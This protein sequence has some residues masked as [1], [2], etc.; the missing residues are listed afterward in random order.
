MAAAVHGAVG[1]DL[2]AVLAGEPGQ[3]LADDVE[4]VVVVHEEGELRG[5]GVGQ[6]RDAEPARPEHHL[7]AVARRLAREVDGPVARVAQDRPAR[8]LALPRGRRR[9][10]P[11]R[12][13]RVR[14]RRAVADRLVRRAGVA[15]PQQ[16]V[17]RGGCCGRERAEEEGEYGGLVKHFGKFF[18]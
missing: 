3:G 4:H 14:E 2:A 13:V 1:L 9:R 11:A 6:A 15:R 7:V 16:R 5:V 10:G 12:P 18:S 8:V 17:D